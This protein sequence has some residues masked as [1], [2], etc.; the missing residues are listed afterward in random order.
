MAVIRLIE[1]V[2]LVWL[3]WFVLSQF[4]LPVLKGDPVLPMFWSMTDAL[5]IEKEKLEQKL[6]DQEAEAEV[7]ALR[8]RLLHK[9]DKD[10]DCAEPVTEEKETE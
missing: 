10:S 4:I 8:K 3:G 9:Q 1:A 2:I 5:E 6:K 7:E